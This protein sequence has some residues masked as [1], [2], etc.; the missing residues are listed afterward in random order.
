MAYKDFSKQRCSLSIARCFRGHALPANLQ[1]GQNRLSGPQLHTIICLSVYSVACIPIYLSISTYPSIYFLSIYPSV[2]LPIYHAMYLSA[3]P[4]IYLTL[5]QK[6]T[7]K[8]LQQQQQRQSK[9]REQPP[10][11]IPAPSR[12]CR[13]RPRRWSFH[14]CE[15]PFRVQPWRVGLIPWTRSPPQGSRK[16][17]TKMW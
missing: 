14:A 12:G 8:Q 16:E 17:A 10:H 11:A 5:E 1:S 6:N 2:Y 3:C 9:Q 4:S 7:S 13:G 15:P